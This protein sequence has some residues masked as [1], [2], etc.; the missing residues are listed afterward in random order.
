MTGCENSFPLGMGM[1]N[2]R[3]I[4]NED[5]KGPFRLCP[6]AIPNQEHKLCSSNV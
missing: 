4:S 2:I 5:K 3:G 1:R 6:A